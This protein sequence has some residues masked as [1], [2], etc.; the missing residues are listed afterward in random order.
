MVFKPGKIWQIIH[1]P[2]I[3]K[4]TR[5]DK[6]RVFLFLCLR[7]LRKLELSHSSTGCS[8]SCLKVL[9]C[10]EDGSA[11]VLQQILSSRAESFHEPSCQSQNIPPVNTA[12]VFLAPL[13][14]FEH[15]WMKKSWAEDLV[16]SSL[17]W[18]RRSSRFDRFDHSISRWWHHLE[19]RWASQEILF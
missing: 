4:S 7:D 19:N 12:C 10:K 3:L 2:V 8:Y 14:I 1:S 15:E 5:T 11:A 13:I 6:T 17:H 18:G 16:W 9:K